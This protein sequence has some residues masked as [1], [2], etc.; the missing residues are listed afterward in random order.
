M[1]KEEDLAKKDNDRCQKQML[2]MVPRKYKTEKFEEMMQDLEDLVEMHEESVEANKEMHRNLSELGMTREIVQQDV[3]YLEQYRV[4]S[5]FR[6]FKLKAE[7]RILKKLC[8]SF[9]IK[10]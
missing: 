4:D 3:R 9:T 10:G 1:K 2:R 5:I 6:I 7:H 8:I